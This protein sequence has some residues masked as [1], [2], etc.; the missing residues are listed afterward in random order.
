MSCQSAEKGLCWRSN[1]YFLVFFFFTVTDFFGGGGRPSFFFLSIFIQ[2]CT[3]WIYSD[4][5]LNFVVFIIQNY[6]FTREWNKGNWM[7][8]HFSWL[9][10]KEDLLEKEIFS[11]GSCGALIHYCYNESC[12]MIIYCICIGSI[13]LFVSNLLYSWKPGIRKHAQGG[14][15]KFEVINWFRIRLSDIIPAPNSTI[16][17]T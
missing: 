14:K 7:D 17:S 5:D 4:L 11:P 3:C 8:P 9:D 15:N 12:E 2:H 13:G 6:Q 1:H 16:C 10:P